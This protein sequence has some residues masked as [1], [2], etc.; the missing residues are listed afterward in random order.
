[1]FI[2]PL[3][4]H[5]AVASRPEAEILTARDKGFWNV[6]SIYGRGENKA[7]LPHASDVLFMCFDDVEEADSRQDRSP[8]ATDLVEVFD[9]I[10]DLDNEP[11]AAPVLFHCQQG[12]SRSAAVALSWIYGQLPDSIAREDLAVEILAE[13]RPQARPNRLVLRHGLSQFL[14]SNQATAMA[15]TLVRHPKLSINRI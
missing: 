7:V 6:V 5:L 10:A 8:Q 9:F 4:R 3:G 2:D 13:L 1:M 15:E 12:L 14:P 11:Q